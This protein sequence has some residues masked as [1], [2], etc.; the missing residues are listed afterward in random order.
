[1]LDMEIPA[2]STRKA[3]AN[4]REICPEVHGFIERVVVPALVKRDIRELQHGKQP[5]TTGTLGESR[6]I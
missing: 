2:E 1:M 3:D 4:A 5:N 6:A